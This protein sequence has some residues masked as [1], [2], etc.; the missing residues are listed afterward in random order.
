[1]RSAYVLTMGNAL[2]LFFAFVLAVALVVLVVQLRADPQPTGPELV[3]E[4]QQLP[5]VVGTKFPEPISTIFILGGASAMGLWKLARK[6][7]LV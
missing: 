2:R 7:N 4:V 3:S 1:M 6:M 5:M